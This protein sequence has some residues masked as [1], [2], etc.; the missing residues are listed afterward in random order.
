MGGGPDPV[1]LA[2]PVD[3][4]GETPR[5]C[6][7]VQG[8]G[9][10]VGGGEDIGLAGIA[11]WTG[12]YEVC[13]AVDTHPGPG[14]DVVHVAAGPECGVAVEA[15]VAEGVGQGD[16]GAG[17]GDPVGT[18]QVVGQV[19]PSP[20]RFLFMRRTS[21]TQASWKAEAYQRGEAGEGVQ[22]PGNSSMLLPW[23]SITRVES[24]PSQLSS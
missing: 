16:T 9:H 4:F 18:E 1:E 22:T 12:E 13:E 23:A 6:V 15:G 24:V 19:G 14:E 21:S 2:W 10:Q 17:Q 3:G 11:G 5:R 7:A 20:R 8:P